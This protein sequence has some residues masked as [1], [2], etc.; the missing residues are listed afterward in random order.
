MCGGNWDIWAVDLNGNGLQPT[1]WREYVRRFNLEDSWHSSL[2]LQGWLDHPLRLLVHSRAG[3]A[4]FLQAAAASA[5]GLPGTDPPQKIT[6]GTG[7]EMQASVAANGRIA[8]GSLAYE[9][10]IWGVPIDDSGRTSGPVRQLTA[11]LPDEIQPVLS[12]NAEHLVFL[13]SKST[14]PQLYGKDLTTGRIRRLSENHGSVKMAPAIGRGGSEVL[15]A[16]VSRAPTSLFAVPFAGG[17]PQKFALAGTAEAPSDWARNGNALLLM[18]HPETSPGHFSIYGADI[19][20][21]KVVPLIQDPEHDVFQ[22]HFSPDARWITFN[23]L[24]NGR[25]R[26]FIAPFRWASIPPAEWIPITGDT[27]WADK[28]R[29]SNDGTSVLFSSDRDGFR[30]IWAQRLTPDMHPAGAEFPVYHSHGSQV[31][32]RNGPLS[33]QGMSV[34]KGLLAF[35]QTEFKGNIWILE[36]R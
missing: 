1:H 18:Q 11:E 12:D 31:S 16:D 36:P 15:Y 23:I 13:S 26:L 3:T 30:C 2:A 14:P 32:I 29:F 19:N 22:A 33:D 6:F 17:V 4:D 7:A 21:G 28:P 35:D 5:D 27:E 9:A 8:V 25:S 20:S 24:A 10:H 34:G